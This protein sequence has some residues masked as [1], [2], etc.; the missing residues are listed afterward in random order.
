MTK[1]FTLKNV[2]ILS[3]LAIV[4][5]FIV[6]SIAEVRDQKAFLDLPGHTLEIGRC[7]YRTH[8]GFE[9]PSC[10][11]T[12]GFISIENLDFP[13]A[14]HF[15]R[16]SPFVYLMFV[17]LGIFNILSLAKKTYALLFG[18]FLAIYSVIVCIAIVLNWIIFY[19]LPL[20]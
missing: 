5:L 18:K 12:R 1:L 8:F 13:M 20:I 3:L 19:V 6:A 14:V 9:C 4:C 7:Y 10:G 17:F 2:H 15:N 11:L 16:M